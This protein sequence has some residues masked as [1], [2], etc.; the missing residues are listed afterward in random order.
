M[1]F[2][3][4]LFIS[5]RVTGTPV[6]RT[7]LVTVWALS[8]CFYRDRIN[9][10]MSAEDLPSGIVNQH[11]SQEA[12][13]TVVAH[14]FLAHWGD[15]WVR[16]QGKRCC[17][18]ARPQAG[19]TGRQGAFVRWRWHE[20]AVLVTHRTLSAVGP[21]LDKRHSKHSWSGF[22][23]LLSLGHF[24]PFPWHCVPVFRIGDPGG[25]TSYGCPDLSRRQL[26]VHRLLSFSGKE[27]A[28]WF[29][30]HDAGQVL[31][32]P[33]GWGGAILTWHCE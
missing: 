11:L 5:A 25:A 30:C 31:G 8:T 32:K 9:E 2:L 28:A 13:Q 7:E 29:D 10:P 20:I 3:P 1:P 12:G 18:S 33:G 14:T 17:P 6:C 26:L 24:S 23:H 22:A 21:S 27:V 15:S 19:H 4:G 16:C